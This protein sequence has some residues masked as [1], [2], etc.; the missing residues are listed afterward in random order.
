MIRQIKVGRVMNYGLI[1]LFILA[2]LVEA[3]LWSSSVMQQAA[4]SSSIKSDFGDFRVTG[5]DGTTLL[6][7]W[8]ENTNVSGTS[9]TWIKFSNIPTGTNSVGW[10]YYTNSGAATIQNFSNVFTKDYPTTDALDNGLVLELHMDETSGFPQDTS[11]QGNHV[12]AGAATQTTTDGGRWDGQNQTFATG[13]HYDFATG[14]YF[15]IPN[16]DSL[17]LATFTIAMWFRVDSLYDYETLIEKGN[18]AAENFKILLFGN[19][20]INCP[21]LWTDASRSYDADAPSG[22]II[23]NQ[24]YLIVYHYAPGNWGIWL[25][26]TQKTLATTT[27]KTPATNTVNLR[28]GYAI[29]NNRPLD[30]QIDEVRI[31]NRILTQAEKMALYERRKSQAVTFSYGAEEASTAL[32]GWSYRRPIT[33]ANNT[34]AAVTDYQGK[35]IL[36]V[37]PTAGQTVVNQ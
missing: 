37:N 27:T 35:I 17:N 1:L 5:T 26:G 16:A 34:G 15:Q 8:H 13:R 31:Y 25:N 9:A 22:T 11:G 3:G 36:N 33:A 7:Y 6:E 2:H 28:M 4:Q 29:G 12:T 18:D 30:G 14:G 32:S 23:I 21:I 24:W 20:Y 19:G 10:M